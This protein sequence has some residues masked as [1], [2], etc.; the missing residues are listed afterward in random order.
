MVGEDPA[1]GDKH[2]A[3]KKP[4]KQK[5]P[6]TKIPGVLLCS[7]NLPPD[8]PPRT[9]QNFALFF[10]SS[11]IF[12]TCTFGLSGCR[13]NGGLRRFKTTKIPR[14][15]P[16][17][18]TQKRA[19]WWR[20]RKK[21]SAK[22]WVLRP[23]GL[24]FF[25]EDVGMTSVLTKVKNEC[26]HMF[27]FRG[28]LKRKLLNTNQSRPCTWQP[29]RL[30]PD[31]R[32]DTLPGPHGRWGCRRQHLRTPSSPGVNKRKHVLLHVPT[33]TPT[34]V[35]MPALPSSAAQEVRSGKMSQ[36]GGG[37]LQPPPCHFS[38]KDH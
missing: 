33:T 5:P 30:P 8:R 12:E 4:R 20:E 15:D 2:P 37:L 38:S 32:N 21:K 10:L 36:E 31:Q 18:E 13:V 22:F 6:E 24:H 17:R 23:S 19:K 35:S 29:L 25:F 3:N 28:R 1:P 11:H 27:F 9:A 26:A 16:Q 7:P 14:E 34:E